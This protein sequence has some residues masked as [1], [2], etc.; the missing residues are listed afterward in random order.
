MVRLILVDIWSKAERF[1]VETM[2]VGLGCVTVFV[3]LLTVSMVTTASLMGVT[4]PAISTAAN[5]S[6]SMPPKTSAWRGGSSGTHHHHQVE[7]KHKEGNLT[8]GLILPHTNFGVRDY[9][10]AIKGAA[11]KLT[12]SRGPKFN[13]LKKFEFSPSQVHSVMM[14]LTPS[15]TGE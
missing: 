5:L 11:E 10:K 4:L 8:I 12:K 9:I 1:D 3:M 2:I 7:K 15:P 14:T 6:S 13:F